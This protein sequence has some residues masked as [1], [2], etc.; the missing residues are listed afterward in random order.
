MSQPCVIWIEDNLEEDIKMRLSTLCDKK[1]WQLKKAEDVSE[2]ADILLTEDPKFI[3]AFVLDMKLSGTNNLSDF[4]DIDKEA[5]VVE[6]NSSIVDAGSLLLEHIFRKQESKYINIPILIL[7]VKRL[8]DL[9][10]I[11]G[12]EIISITKRDVLDSK[13]KEGVNKFFQRLT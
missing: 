9:S 2:L 4:K 7:S 11:N 8:V 1:Q 5:S 13:W 6:W 3:K 10:D 12:G